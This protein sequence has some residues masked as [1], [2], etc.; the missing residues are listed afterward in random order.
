MNNLSNKLRNAFNVLATFSEGR[1]SFSC[2]PFTHSEGIET[3]FTTP[4]LRCLELL[5]SFHDNTPAV[6]VA[7]GSISEKNKF[8]FFFYYF[9]ICLRVKS[10]RDRER[11]VR[12]TVSPF[13][14]P[15][16]FLT[17]IIS[18]YSKVIGV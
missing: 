11:G 6:Y 8:S 2:M 16:S 14:F 17:F 7:F 1:T 9:S 13:I 18:P 12:R 5:K 4:D 15:P 10:W 3:N